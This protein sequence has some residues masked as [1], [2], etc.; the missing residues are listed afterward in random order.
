MPSPAMAKKREIRR[1]F[2]SQVQRRVRSNYSK[3]DDTDDE[4]IKCVADHAFAEERFS[5]DDLPT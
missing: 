5:W 2:A 1:V 4:L 3:I